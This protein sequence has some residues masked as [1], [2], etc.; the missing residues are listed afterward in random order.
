MPKI[1]LQLAGLTCDTC[2]R[3]VT[4]VLRGNDHV[5]NIFHVDLTTADIEI[6]DA[7]NEAVKSL[8]EDITEIG[9]KVS[10]Y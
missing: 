1:K 6:D 4:N 3:N 10:V 5:L 7:S 2:E 9:Y 8:I